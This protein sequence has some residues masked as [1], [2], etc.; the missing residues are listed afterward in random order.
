MHGGWRGLS[1]GRIWLEQSHGR[2]ARLLLV[3]VC[4]YAF[5]QT[6]TWAYLAEAI[7]SKRPSAIGIFCINVALPPVFMWATYGSVRTAWLG[8]PPDD[9]RNGA[10]PL[11]A[12]G[13]GAVILWLVLRTAA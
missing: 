12:V 8:G 2:P 4:C 3:N 6:V 1:R 10:V 13:L 7:L 5:F 11:L 9:I